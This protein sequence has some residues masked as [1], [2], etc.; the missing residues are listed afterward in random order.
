MFN[1]AKSS[2]VAG[3][4]ARTWLRRGVPVNMGRRFVLLI[5]LFSSAVTLVS[6]A[7]QLGL[8]Y[9][10]DVMAIRTQL[11]QIRA[12]YDDSLASSVWTTNI[13]DVNL[14]L[15]GILRLPDLPYVEVLNEQNMVLAHAGM[16]QTSNLIVESF[17]LAYKLRDRIFNIGSVRLQATLNGADQR[18][19]EKVVVIL[20]AQTI[21]TFLV[22]LFIL[23]LFQL[24]V[25][26]HLKKIAAH[27]DLL[28]A[29]QLAPSLEL[30]RTSTPANHHDE[31]SQVVQALNSMHRRVNSSFLSMQESLIERQRAEE[32]LRLLNEQ[33]EM[34]IEERTRELRYAMAQMIESEKLAALGK[35]VA[36]VAHELNTPIGNIMLASS[37]MSA[38]LVELHSAASNNGLTRSQ[39]RNGLAECQVA[40]EI[41]DRNSD[42]A[43]ELI[44][45]FKRVAADQPSQLRRRFNLRAFVLDCLAAHG[46]AIRNAGAHIEIEIQNDIEMD[47]YPG[48]LEQIFSNLILNS[49]THGFV[50]RSD[51]TIAIVVRRHGCWVEVD[52]SDNGHGIAQELQHRIFEPFYTTLLGQGSC[53][54]GMTIVYNLVKS[55]FKGQVVLE[56][57]REQGTRLMLTLLAESD[58]TEQAGVL[59]TC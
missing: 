40:G 52:F 59:S 31:L 49:C 26:R 10:R 30:Q 14:Q 32:A 19:R 20:I 53:G 5:L 42:R 45:S 55:V 16:V 37:A 43:A 47:S 41:I 33:L 18:L 48:H 17:P 54:L 7:F 39:L 35:L 4:L 56:S 57:Q 44:A 50:G 29:S 28:S 3:Q 13:N 38:Q 6:T 51:C 46:P 9:H 15:Q 8:E 24:M 58:N 2:N 36:G 22:S 34:L 23:A 11:Q 21:K 25:G 1:A 12:S 27:S